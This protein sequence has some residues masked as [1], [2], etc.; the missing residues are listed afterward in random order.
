MAF[1]TRTRRADGLVKDT[2]ARC[3][4]P[5]DVLP[6]RVS[7]SQWQRRHECFPQRLRKRALSEAT[8]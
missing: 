3:G 2:C 7:E 6:E 1:F 4:V 8:R 5:G